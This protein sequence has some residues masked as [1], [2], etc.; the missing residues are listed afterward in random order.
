MKLAIAALFLLLLALPAGAQANGGCGEGGRCVVREGYYLAEAPADWDGESAL[1]IVVFIHGWNSSPEGM[2][3]NRA[4]VEG[5]TRRGALF[6]VPWAQTGYWRQIGSGRAEGGRDELAYMKTL[7]ADIER[8]WPVDRR[9]S[10]VSGFSRGASLV[11]NLACYAGDMFEAY[12]PIAGGF[13]NSNPK[14]CPG[15]PVNLRHIHGRSDR[16]VALDE[17]GIYNS[18]PIPEGLTILQQL[19]GCAAE[20]QAE[21]AHARYSC[22]VWSACSS[23]RQLELCLHTGGHSIPAEW[24]VEGYDWMLSLAAAQ[25]R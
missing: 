11:W 14:S 9:R 21:Q 8:R 4:L 7:M 25:R 12:L 5:I 10:L 1:P 15:G 24:V 16:V 18:M 22:E 17:I 13:W 3:R 2:F 20:P 6:V 19:N 23:G